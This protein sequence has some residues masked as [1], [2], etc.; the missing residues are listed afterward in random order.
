MKPYQTQPCQ[1][2]RLHRL[3]DELDIFRKS[4]LSLANLLRNA[5]SP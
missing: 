2:K 4:A 3:H 5:V 1:S